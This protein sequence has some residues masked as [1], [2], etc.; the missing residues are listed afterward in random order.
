MRTLKLYGT[1]T[2]TANA[3]A[4][5]VI[6]SASTIRAIQWSVIL[7]S[8]TDGVLVQ[9]ELSRSSS[10]ET[11]VNG[12]QQCCAEI[13]LASNFVTSGLA[14]PT[15][16]GIFHVSLPFAQGQILYTHALITGT[17]TYHVTWLLHY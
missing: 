3:V 10:R 16:N 11:N 9:L 8:I 15:P 12:A 17:V 13:A 14:Q 1:G 6:P 4:S 5:V 7:D 2:A